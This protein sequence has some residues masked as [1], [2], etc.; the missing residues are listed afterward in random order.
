MVQRCQPPPPPMVM[1]QTSTPPPPCGCGCGF[2]KLSQLNAGRVLGQT[3]NLPFPPLWMWFLFTAT[4]S[5]LM[6]PSDDTFRMWILPP[7][8]CSKL[9]QVLPSP[10]H[11]AFDKYGPGFSP[12]CQGSWI[13]S[14]SYRKDLACPFSRLM[15]GFAGFSVLSPGR[16]CLQL[17]LEGGE[18][19]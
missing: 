7:N 17:R 1:G 12:H 3:S 4:W 8:H 10:V 14:E 9:R 13:T 11:L 18:P 2:G 6:N 16:V 15:T 5:V 19:R